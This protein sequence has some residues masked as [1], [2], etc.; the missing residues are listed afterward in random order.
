[1]TTNDAFNEYA[2]GTGQCFNMPRC[3]NLDEWNAHPCSRFANRPV[4][5][6]VFDVHSDTDWGLHTIPVKPGGLRSADTLPLGDWNVI[7]V[8]QSPEQRVCDPIKWASLLRP[9]KLAPT[10]AVKGSNHDS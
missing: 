4:V 5:V 7:L 10:H 3:R 8:N 1:M 9:A 2:P 6:R